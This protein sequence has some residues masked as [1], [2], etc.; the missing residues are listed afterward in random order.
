M[1]RPHTGGESLDR[2][3][4][5]LLC[6][7]PGDPAASHK[8]R[9][10]RQGQLAGTGRETD[11]GQACEERAER[12]PTGGRRYGGRVRRRGKKPGVSGLCSPGCVR[13]AGETGTQ[14]H[15]LHSTVV[16]Q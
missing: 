7:Q 11:A 10:S 1:E 15:T 3:V 2:K 6:H 5:Q 12:E 8:S 9:T 4:T 13:E 16:H 14:L